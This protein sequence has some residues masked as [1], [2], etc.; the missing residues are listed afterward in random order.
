[1]IFNNKKLKLVINITNQTDLY[2]LSYWLQYHKNI[3]N[4]ISVITNDNKI[5]FPYCKIIYNFNFNDDNYIELTLND[6]LIIED[7]ENNCDIEFRKFKAYPNKNIK[8]EFNNT[9]ELLNNLINEDITFIEEEKTKSTNKSFIINIEN[10]IKNKLIE[11]DLDE[12]QD[13]SKYIYD[14]LKSKYKNKLFIVTGGCGFIGSHLVDEL[15]LQ[16]HKVIVIDN[17]LSGNIK[18]LNTNDNVIYENIDINNV[19]LLNKTIED[20]D[21]IDGIY[22]LAEISDEKLC[23]TNPLL[24]YNTNIIGCVNILE[25]ARKKN[26]NKVIISSTNIKYPDLSPYKISKN[27]IEDLIASYIEN[28]KMNITILKYPI[29]YGRRQIIN[30]LNEITNDKNNLYISD[31]ISANI[32]A[33]YS[34]FNGILNLYKEDFEATDKNKAYYEIG[35]KSRIN[36]KEGI[37]MTSNNNYSYDENDNTEEIGFIILRHVNNEET[38]CYWQLCYKSIRNFYPNNKIVIIDDDSNNDYLKSNINLYKTKIIES[39]YPRRGELLPYY[40]Y[41]KYNFF[42]IAVILHDSVVI[43]RFINF[44]VNTYTM[45][46]DIDHDCDDNENDVRIIKEF[47]NENLTNFYYNK[48]FW[49]GCFGSMTVIKHDF[50]SS[51]NSIFNLNTLLPVILTRRDRSSFERILAC[52]LQLNERYSCLISSITN[53]RIAFQLNYGTY[54]NDQDKYNHMPIVKYWTGR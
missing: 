12:Y 44:N 14:I 16:G 29:V 47:K 27:T 3:F 6:F 42:N 41:N 9:F 54:I 53:F 18:N 19:E 10:L 43:N 7:N 21:N 11:K 30:N 4:D 26:I 49:K 2:L 32:L 28:Y 40:Y 23:I 36:I 38:N 37:E 35:W 34:I 17:L 8:Y 13:E 1:M 45:I 31:I 33:Y 20:Y 24:C 48:L 22:H 52:L 46:W 50:L 15:I 51:I 39:E 25:L 5:D